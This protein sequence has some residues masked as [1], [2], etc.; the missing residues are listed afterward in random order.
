VLL[1]VAAPAAPAALSCAGAASRPTS[2]T[3]E[4]QAAATVCLIN[5]ARAAHGLGPLRSKGLLTRA[6][7]AHAQEMVRGDSLSHTGLDGSS[8]SQRVIRTGYLGG[9]RAWAVGETIA[10]GTG[11]L[12]SPAAI[13]RSWLTSPPHRAIL[14]DGRYHDIGIGIALGALDSSSGSGAAVT[15][16]LGARR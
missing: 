3:L 1:A 10:W 12:A 13:V 9:A 14:L 6:A 2:A 5:R 15:A 4:R 8:P 16:D 11:R 7:R